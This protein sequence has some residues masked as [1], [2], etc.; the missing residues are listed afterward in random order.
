MAVQ[1]GIIPILLR[2]ETTKNFWGTVEKLAEI[3]Y[4]GIESG[5]VLQGD[6]AENKKKL[7]DLGIKVVALGVNKEIIK[8]EKLDDVAEKARFLDCHYV[9][10]YWGPCNNFEQVKADAQIYDEI[11]AKF[12]THGLKY[13]YHNHDHEFKTKFDGKRAIDVLLENSD[14]EHLFLELDVAWVKYGGENPVSF[15]KQHASRIPIIHLKDIADIS[16][17]GMFTAIL[18]G[19]VAVNE[20]MEAATELGVDWAVVEQDR[21]NRLTPLESVQASYLNL[22]ECGWV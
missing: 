8:A 15:L 1:V 18:T 13:C 21:V 10:T 9:V 19:C 5:Q 11:G 14:P 2:E 16:E 4:R 6:V 12:R 20:V 17:R 7:D 3:G 22:K